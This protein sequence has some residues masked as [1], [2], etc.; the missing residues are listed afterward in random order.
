MCAVSDAVPEPTDLEQRGLDTWAGGTEWDERGAEHAAEIITWAAMDENISVRWLETNIDG[1]TTDSWKLFK[2]PNS[3]PD[4]LAAAFELL[5]GDV[6]N[7]RLADDPRNTQPVAEM[8]SLEAR[9]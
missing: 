6:P 7:L 5:T 3:N 4:Q 2:V 8:T 9:R 1:T